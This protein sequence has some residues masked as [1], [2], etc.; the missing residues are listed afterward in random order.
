MA[1]LTLKVAH[2]RALLTVTMPGDSRVACLKAE[3]S[4]LIGVAPRNQT[5]IS[6]GR[7]LADTATLTACGLAD[8][9]KLLLLG[10]APTKPSGS[11][12]RPEAPAA[13]SSARL[14][15]WNKT[16]VVSLRDASLAA[17][18][19]E[20][21]SVGS[22]ARVLDLS[23][24]QHLTSLGTEV[25]GLCNL[26]R[27]NVAGCSVA[28]VAWPELTQLRSLTHLTLARNRLTTLPPSIAQL[29]ALQQLD[30]SG[31]ALLT[32]LPSLDAL[33]ALQLLDASNCALHEVPSMPASITELRLHYNPITALPAQLGT[34]RD[35]A[36]LLA[37]KCRIPQDGVPSAL[38]RS[39]SLHTLI[40]SDNPVSAEQLRSITGFA[41]YEARRVA[42]AGRALAA[43]VGGASAAFQ[44]GADVERHRRF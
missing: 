3:L 40:L 15:G 42:K 43:G 13:L 37:S 20:V 34:C 33:P 14:A 7:K 25:A 39:P 4:A 9:A 41:E 38:L 22:A 10:P 23:G 12:P 36:V 8:G 21:W 35:L 16:G 2:G 28:V 31:N 11:V 30:V 26:T 17:C 27:L 5:L 44:Q 19:T 29:A 24:N 6:S 32:A 1:L 18:P